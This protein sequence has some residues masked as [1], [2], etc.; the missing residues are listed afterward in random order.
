MGTDNRHLKQKSFAFFVVFL[1][2]CIFEIS[3][4]GTTVRK[5]SKLFWFSSHLFVSL[6]Q[7]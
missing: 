6:P 2:M 5:N 1:L 3:L 7:I 4:E